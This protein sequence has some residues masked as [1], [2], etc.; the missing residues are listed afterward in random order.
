MQRTYKMSLNLYGRQFTLLL[1]RSIPENL[2]KKIHYSQIHQL[3]IQTSKLLIFF[4]FIPMEIRHKSQFIWLAQFPAKTLVCLYLCKIV[5]IRRPVPSTNQA[6][7]S[8]FYFR[9][10][11]ILMEQHCFYLF[12]PLGFLQVDTGQYF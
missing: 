2:V 3:S 1:W 12:C 4:C 10:S 5:Y 7:P 6:I 8:C 11:W 9:I